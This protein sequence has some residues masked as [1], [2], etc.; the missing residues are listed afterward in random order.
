MFAHLL[1]TVLDGQI[2]WS[3]VDSEIRYY[4]LP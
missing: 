3:R 1:D 4:A 2:I